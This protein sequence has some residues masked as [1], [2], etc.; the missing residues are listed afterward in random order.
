M[1]EHENYIQELDNTIKSEKQRKLD[2]EANLIELETLRRKDHNRIQELKGNIR[3]FCRVRPCLGKFLFLFTK[4][5][6]LSLS[7]LLIDMF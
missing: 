3:V 2:L 7:C 4:L 6:S 1:T 5:L